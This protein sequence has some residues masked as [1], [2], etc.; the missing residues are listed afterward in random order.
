M[1][2]IARFNQSIT[3][4]S[5]S[6]VV[7]DVGSRKLPLS[8]PPDPTAPLPAST[9]E[10]T[11][12]I[13]GRPVVAPTSDEDDVVDDDGASGGGEQMVNSDRAIG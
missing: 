5:P 13:C 3:M 7:K 8:R 4:N 9:S 12:D 11:A 2:S 1:P 10:V 6:P